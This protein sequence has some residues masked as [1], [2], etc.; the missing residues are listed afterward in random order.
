M[1]RGLR[2]ARCLTALAGGLAAIG[3]LVG[4]IAGSARPVI[5][6]PAGSPIAA[7]EAPNLTP[8]PDDFDIPNGH[9]FSQT[10]R[11]VDP[12][13]ITLLQNLSGT[14]RLA[15][16]TL[17]ITGFTV[18][19]ETEIPFWT[20]YRAYG[21]VDELGYPLSQRL[22]WRGATVQ[23]MQRNIL[24]WDAAGKQ[25]TLA[26]TFD[27][28]HDLGHDQWLSD[29][30]KVP[31]P[32]TST[33]PATATWEE[34]RADRLSLL[35]LDP[36]IEARYRANPRAEDSYGLPVSIG[37]YDEVIVLRTQ[38]A[39]FQHWKI[40]TDFAKAGDVTVANGGELAV[41]AGIVPAD[42]RLVQRSPYEVGQS[43]RIPW[44]GWWWPAHIAGGDPQ[45]WQP[46]GPYDKFDRYVQSLGRP[47]PGVAAWEREN[48]RF[49]KPDED[50]A[51]HCNGWAAAAL[52][53]PEPTEP[54]T[55]NGITFSIGDQ[56][57]LLSGYHFGDEASWVVGGKPD[58]TTPKELRDAL[59]LWLG[60]RHRGFLANLYSGDSQV[61]SAPAFKFET[62]YGPD[63]VKPNVNHFKTKIWYADYHVPPNYV[64]TQVF[65]G[66]P[67]LYEYWI[68]GPF[69]QPTDMGW[70]GISASTSD[71]ARP[72]HIW[73]PDVTTRNARRSPPGLS[74]DVIKQIVPGAGSLLADARGTFAYRSFGS[75]ANPLLPNS[76]WMPD[77]GLE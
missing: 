63:P 8:P 74:Y 40:D 77:R 60:G 73:Y 38:R 2:I 29:H 59:L 18:T 71:F 25:T 46:G 14:V 48:M 13:Q 19:N 62:I 12:E 42:A 41:E 43:S 36:V 44:S 16:S 75:A 28:L 61:W 72:Y 45:L 51:G 5:A 15:D 21:G 17:G 57:G 76:F 34:V 50:W 70:E 6:G 55:R 56:K 27:L 4:P 23:V 47:D 37:E 49:E 26:N 31:P 22:T 35:A 30:K 9:F 69:D 65:G 3:L 33:L 66:E 24:V 67:K 10:G 58:G 53:E 64:G 68:E 32:F 1:S 7:D 20:A 11:Q 52:L 54:V 39:A